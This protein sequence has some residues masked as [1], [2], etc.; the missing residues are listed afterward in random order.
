MRSAGFTWITGGG[1]DR[2]TVR[3]ERT[4]GRRRA[5]E[6]QKGQGFIEYGLILGLMALVAIL[7]LTLFGSQISNLV[8]TFAQ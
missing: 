5:R 7:A 1:H 2:T 3:P 4:K 8:N 6:E